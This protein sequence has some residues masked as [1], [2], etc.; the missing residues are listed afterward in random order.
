M[1][2]IFDQG[3]PPPCPEP[4]NLAAY[5]LYRAGD[6]SEKTALSV[7]SPDGAETWSYG[8][9]EAA[10][11]GAATG[12]KEQGLEPGDRLLMRLG[13][14]VEFPICY[15]A[16]LAADIIPVPTSALLTEE[17]VSQICE[18]VSPRLIV[19]G[20]GSPCRLTRRAR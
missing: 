5:V 15:L 14:S 7:V 9:L 16:A 4:F 3:P 12:L 17:E 2:A 1:D 8:A 10:V 6:L 18:D 19:A 11:L 20:A 13:N